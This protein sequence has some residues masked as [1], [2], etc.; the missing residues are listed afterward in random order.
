VS[1]S[2]VLRVS[3]V[4][5]ETPSTRIVRLD[6]AGQRFVYESGQTVMIGI[7]GR[8]ERVP[9]SIASCPEETRRFGWLELLIK[10]E[11]S[12]RWGHKFDR[13]GRGMRIALRGPFG[14]FTFPA[15]PRDRDF[16]F[17]AGGTG[18]APIRSMIRH[19]QLA[20][21]PGRARLLY[22]ARTPGEF[23]YVRELRAVARVRRLE[24]T[25]TATGEVGTGWRGGRGRVAAAHL[26]PLVDR[27]ETL[28]FVCG[29]AAMV[30]DVPLMLIGLGIPKS[31][32]RVEEW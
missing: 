2:L 4:R 10:V 26:S 21:V 25:L 27:R 6:L 30:A 14:S 20:R 19:I 18:I 7:A 3:S 32:I 17:I 22:S 31:K 16:L 24:L 5:R 13:I 8:E 1:D 9:Y 23:P 15:R 12:G 11:P 29:P 28:C